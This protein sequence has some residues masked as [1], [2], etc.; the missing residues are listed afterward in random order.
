MSI[1]VIVWGEVA[2]IVGEKPVRADANGGREMYGVCGS[3]P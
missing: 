2:T 1:S 3:K